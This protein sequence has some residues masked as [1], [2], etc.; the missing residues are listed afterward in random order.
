M[1]VKEAVSPRDPGKGKW[2]AT[3][4][5]VY[6]QEEIRRGSWTLRGEGAGVTGE[7]LTSILQAMERSW[8]TPCVR[9]WCLEK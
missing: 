7:G 9:G 2:Y 4:V 1:P 8:L 3:E 5:V 6:K